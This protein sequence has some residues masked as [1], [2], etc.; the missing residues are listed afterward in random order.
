M[1]TAGH[2]LAG[3]LAEARKLMAV[4]RQVDPGLRLSDVTDV[5]PFRNKEDVSRYGDALRAA[6]LPA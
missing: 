6:G 4:M 1:A 5:A 2:A 3:R